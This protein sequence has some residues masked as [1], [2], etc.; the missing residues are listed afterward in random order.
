MI[1]RIEGVLIE[2][3]DGRAHVQCGGLVY[4]VLIPAAD[5]G[6]LTVSIGESVLLHTLHLL[7]GAA[8][9]TTLRP[10]L[11][12]FASA[13]DRQFFEMFTTVKGIGARKALRVMQLPVGRIALA[14]SE[15]DIALLTSLPE[16]GKRTAEA[17]VVE[18]KEK[19]EPFID[20]TTTVGGSDESVRE[21]VTEFA[22]EAIAVLLQLGEPR[23][24][25]EELVDRATRADPEIDT[26]DQL[27]TSALRLKQLG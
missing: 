17:I 19:V 10:R 16:V 6:R 5:E 3:Q 25:A 27:V 7:E 4:E 13:S 24:R 21:A 8:Q 9:G 18:L 1:S 12:G 11:I 26:A 14:V 15:H 23:A 22:K 20:T 2:V